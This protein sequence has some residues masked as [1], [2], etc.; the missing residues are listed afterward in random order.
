[1]QA[2]R[3]SAQP[4]SA[5]ELPDT[6]ENANSIIALPHNIE[7][8]LAQLAN[9]LQVE[10]GKDRESFLTE[11]FKLIKHLKDS[12]N[13]CP[14]GAESLIDDLVNNLVAP[15]KQLTSVVPMDL[16]QDID[17]FGRVRLLMSDLA[18]E[19]I[20]MGEVKGLSRYELRS[21]LVAHAKSMMVVSRTW[22]VTE[23]ESGERKVECVRDMTEAARTLCA[24][25]EELGFSDILKAENI[26]TID[27]CE[28]GEI[29]SQAVLH[30]VENGEADPSYVKLKARI[31]NESITKRGELL[32]ELRPFV[33]SS[34]AV[35]IADNLNLEL[36]SALENSDAANHKGDFQAML[37]E[38]GVPGAINFRAKNAAQ[39]AVACLIMQAVKDGTPNDMGAKAKANRCA[40][41][42]GI[43]DSKSP[44]DTLK[45][46]LSDKDAAQLLEKYGFSIMEWL[47]L[48]EEKMPG[49]L[50]YIHPSNPKLDRIVGIADQ[51]MYPGTDAYQG[52]LGSTNLQFWGQKYP[53]LL[54]TI[55]DARAVLRAN[56]VTGFQGLDTAQEQSK[57]GVTMWNLTRMN[58]MVIVENN[59]R[60]TGQTHVAYRAQKEGFEYY[61]VHNSISIPE[62]MDFDGFKQHLIDEGLHYNEGGNEGGIFIT[63][64]GNPGY[65][66]VG[67]LARSMQ[68]IKRYYAA[69]E[70][71]STQNKREEEKAKSVDN[72][73]RLNRAELL[74]LLKAQGLGPYVNAA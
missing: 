56:G 9:E 31:L 51:V 25:F 41:G 53:G 72:I 67:I 65:M 4:N 6:L 30:A 55:D 44:V 50:I 15:N 2:T 38:A 28:D 36:D 57:E 27:Y 58:P 70:A 37:R 10:L 1:M 34:E 63:N 74:P 48:D 5:T 23:D 69:V 73:V 3:L 68:E 60:L 20:G 26:V 39:A 66:M 22:R 47:K 21:M 59:K 24:Y 54:E 19:E 52:S 40:S 29:L 61:G 8:Q 13:P 49:V 64:H 7:S 32:N 33:N 35:K 45:K 18:A 42:Q 14:E 46:L 16:S 62:G 12:R 11:A 17:P 71:Y 43:V